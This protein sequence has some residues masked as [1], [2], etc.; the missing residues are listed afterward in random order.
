MGKAERP[1]RDQ[2]G[3]QRDARGPAK[4]V[5]RSPDQHIDEAGER[6][7]REARDARNDFTVRRDAPATRPKPARAPRTAKARPAADLA[8]D[9]AREL[10]DAAGARRAPTL[11]KRLA[12]AVRAFE[13]ERYDDAAKA[14]RR[15]A[16]A[17]PTSGAIRELNGLALYRLGRW[18]VARKELEAAHALTGSFATHPALADC[19]R[20][21]GR[22]TVVDRLWQELR[23]ASPAPEVLAE[24][25]IVMASSLA[26][27][28]RLAEAIEL[29]KPYEAPRARPK[30]FHLRTWYVLGD[31]YER[32]GDV[33]HARELFRRVLDADAGFYDSAERLARL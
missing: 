27:R 12:D 5:W 24:G 17:A 1:A 29:L 31:L 21:L 22:H 11:E 10:R 7:A 8:P 3:G 4:K 32:A 30:P 13:A 18:R 2:R 20:A 23:Q 14:L 26:E 16:E 19:Y 15:L 25:R 28:E 6:A 9:L 33:P